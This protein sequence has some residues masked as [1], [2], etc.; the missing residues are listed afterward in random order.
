MRS[1]QM[2]SDYADNLGGAKR[3]IELTERRLQ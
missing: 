2:I 3:A 1:A